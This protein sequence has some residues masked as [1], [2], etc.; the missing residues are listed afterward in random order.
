M[1]FVLGRDGRVSC[2]ALHRASGPALRA[3]PAL[4]VM[5]WSPHRTRVVGLDGDTSLWLS[6][7]AKGAMVTTLCTLSPQ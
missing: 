4:Y 7:T 5:L 6:W 2:S 1:V 3:V